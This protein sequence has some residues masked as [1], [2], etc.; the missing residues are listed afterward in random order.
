MKNI[1]DWDQ[2]RTSHWGLQVENTIINSDPGH[3]PKTF[4]NL[5]SKLE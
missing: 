5:Q 3:S 1:T 4:P 2:W